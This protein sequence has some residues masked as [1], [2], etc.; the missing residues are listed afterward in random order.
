MGSSTAVIDRQF[1]GEIASTMDKLTTRALQ[2]QVEAAVSRLCVPLCFVNFIPVTERRQ[3]ELEQS[4]TGGGSVSGRT[5]QGPS[6]QCTCRGILVWNDDSDIV[7]SKDTSRFRGL[8]RYRS[9]ESPSRTYEDRRSRTGR[10][11]PPHC[12]SRGRSYPDQGIGGR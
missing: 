8:Q 4:E 10:S 12:R 6:T 5:H 11:Y 3:G 1:K 7:L 9:R 2:A